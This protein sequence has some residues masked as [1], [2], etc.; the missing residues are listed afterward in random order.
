M[1]GY[2]LIALGAAVALLLALLVGHRALRMPAAVLL[3][4][5]RRW[6]DGEW[7][8]RAHMPAAAAAEFGALSRA[9]NDMAEIHQHQRGEL[10][11]LNEALE[12]RVADRTRALLESNNR[13]QVEIAERELTEANLRQAQKL[14]A[15][16][17]LAGGIAHEFNNLL[18]AVLGSVELLRKWLTEADSR[19]LRQLE[20][21][22]HCVERGS[23]L[24]SQLLA[25]SRKQSLLAVPL[26]VAEAIQGMQGLLATTLGPSVQIEVRTDPG[27]WPAMLDPN[28]FE[29]AILNLAL[30][31]RDA[32]PDGGRLTIT[33][34]NLAVTPARA[35]PDWPEG[36]YVCLIVMDSGTGMSP[37][38]IS[39]AFEPFFTTKALGSGSGLG[40]SQVHGMVRQSGGT[41][42]IDSRPGSGTKITILLPRTT[43][44]P[45]PHAA[46]QLD[47]SMP[48][49]DR[50]QLILLVDDDE[51]VRGV[52]ATML[53][54]NGY[55]VVTAVDGQS[56]LDV[57]EREGERVALVV[58]DYAMPGMTGRQLLD[59]VRQ[60]RPDV[61]L[62]LA[63][64]YADYPLLTADYLPIDQI[65]RKPFRSN[66]LLA[67][68][69]M[70]HE[71]RSSLNAAV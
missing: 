24:T 48:A 38:V 54:E 31:A 70:V 3:Q 39:R 42:S 68:I 61:P 63:T 55:G 47:R 59:A 66:E 46:S 18:T 2:L 50:N 67:R 32:M 60:R 69:H 5:A 44:S 4:A 14:Q 30:N 19:Q 33:A 27:L 6:S 45:A 58:A 40:L 16:G 8:V 13:L 53:A 1:R 62:L 34:D 36:D 23:R 28:Q 51:Q 15:L 56:A 22:A 65:I 12:L 37:E 11:S 26:D 29:A 7:E 21:V 25:F 35:L 9:F 57:L 41:V 20:S 64:G 43:L 10:Q 17:Q 71:R 49:L 52:T